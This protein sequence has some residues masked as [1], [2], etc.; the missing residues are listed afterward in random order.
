MPIFLA[1]PLSD[2]HLGSWLHCFAKNF[3]FCL[4]KY[5]DMAGRGKKTT[6]KTLVKNPGFR[7]NKDASSDS[8]NDQAPGRAGDDIYRDEVLELH[9][10]LEQGELL[11]DSDSDAQDADGAANRDVAANRRV[12]PPGHDN[13]AVNR[14]LLDLV[15]SL[16]AKQAEMAARMN[17]MKGQLD[18]E[19]APYVWKKEGLRLQHNLAH[20]SV[21]K[22]TNAIAAMDLQH[23]DRARENV[24]ATIDLQTQR[25]KELKIADTSEAGW[26]TVNAYKANP[27]AEN[28]DDDKR[29]QRAEKVG[30]ER[31]EAKARKSRF[32]GGR[33]RFNRRPYWN[34]RDDNDRD[35]PYS[36]TGSMKSQ[37]SQ[38]KNGYTPNPRRQ[39]SN[40][41]FYCG[42][43]GHWQNECPNKPQP[44]K[45]D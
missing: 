43:P 13:G 14:E 45:E 18:K 35:Y 8:E 6:K 34:H 33:G 17:E 26:E 27:I 41:C 31:M 29:L 40:L 19:E 22:L 23:H 7:R 20:S 42:Q 10:Q 9:D 36:N 38:Q 28:S 30:K 25:M 39:N 32:G 37:D 4:S 5:A 1:D 15:A 3:Y 21:A 11:D 16:Q 24:K 12:I 2:H 44:K